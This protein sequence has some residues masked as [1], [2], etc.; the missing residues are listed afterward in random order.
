MKL[1]KKSARSTTFPI[2]G[3]LIFISLFM[4]ARSAFAAPQVEVMH[5]W[6]RGGESRAM[7][8]LKDEFELRGGTWFDVAGDKQITVLN[9]AVSR[10]A[11]GYAPTLVQ[12]NSSWDISQI[13]KLGLLNSIEPGPLELLKKKYINNVLDMVM[14]DGELVAIPVNVHSENW[15]W[16]KPNNLP[17]N[18]DDVMQSWEAFLQFAEKSTQESKVAIA[19]GDEPWQRRILFNNILLGVADQTLYE[20]IY[21]EL[22]TSVLNDPKFQDAVDTFKNIKEY[23]QSFGEGRWDQQVAAVAANKALTVSM[24]DWAK[25]EFRNLGLKLE[26]DYSCIPAPGTS[27]N[28]V[29]VMDMFALGKV[30]NVNENIGQN[31]FLDVVTDRAVSEAFNYLKGSLSPL[32]ETNISRLDKC[33]EIAYK[34]IDKRGKAIKPHASIGDRKFIAD[35][36][37]LITILWHEEPDTASWIASFK[38][39]LLEEYNRRLPS[40]L[41]LPESEMTLTNSMR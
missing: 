15:L 16:F 39:L 5:W 35:I 3:S 36:D 9:D 28:I 7:H 19:V 37:H 23:S 1:F 31:L 38:N 8:V 26:R 24:G 29:L 10:M 18:T 27:D 22:D 17:E 41:L 14:V 13:H 6:Y 30:T 2:F 32:R 21:N 34:A 40:D 20:K 12:W 11:K 4:F 25:G 33:N